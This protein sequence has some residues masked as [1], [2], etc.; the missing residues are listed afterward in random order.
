MQAVDELCDFLRFGR[1]VR[2]GVVV[3]RFLGDRD[4]LL[5]DPHVHIAF[6]YVGILSCVFGDDFGNGGSPVKR[7]S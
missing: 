3:F 1:E 5:E 6:E 4:L 2:A 7:K